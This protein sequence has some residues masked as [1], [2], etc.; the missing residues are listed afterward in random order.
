MTELRR[1]LAAST[2]AALL[3]ALTGLLCQTVALSWALHGQVVAPYDFFTTQAYD[4]LSKAR[5]F[6]DNILFWAPALPD[7]FSGPSLGSHLKL[8]LLFAPATFTV[9]VTL[10]LL[11]AV[12]GALVARTRVASVRGYLLLLAAVGLCIHVAAAIPPLNLADMSRWGQLP[13][14]LRSLIIDG[15]LLSWV[16]FAASLASAWVL[17][18]RLKGAPQ[19]AGIAGLAVVLTAAGHLSAEQH[20]PSVPPEFANAGTTVPKYN[21]VLISLDSLRADHVGCYGYERDTSPT[22]DRLASEGIRF[23]NAISTSSWTLPTHLTM[24]TARYQISHGVTD[25][26]RTLASSIPT[27][28]EIMKANGYRTGGFISGPYVAGHYGYARGMDTYVDLSQGYDHRREAR[29]TIASPA[30]NDNALEWLADNHS[31][32]F[33]LFLHYFDIHYDFIPP[34]PYDTMFDPDYTGTMDGTA[35]IERKDVNPEMD[36]RDLEHILALYDGEIRFTDAH[37]GKILDQLAA[38]G[39]LENTL[40][41]LVSDHGDEFFEHGNKGHHRTVYDEVLRVPFVARLPKQARAG[42]VIDEQVSLVDVMPSILD[43]TGIE[44]P[45]DMEGQSVFQIS[46]DDENEREA[47]YAEFFDKRGFNV[48]LARRTE[49]AKTIQH[50]NRITHPDGGG[51]E[52]FL[53]PGDFHESN[54]LAEDAAQQS[55]LRQ[56]LEASTQWLNQRW[57]IYR[58]FQARNQTNG[59]AVEIDAD[60]AE[61]LKSLG[62]MGDD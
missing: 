16:S 6:A 42:T 3:L 21:V 30:I 22:I 56:E 11:C 35:F 37:V 2:C 20:D 9:A 18:P 32:P 36:P 25:D 40:V 62:Y 12:P 48:Q 33:F 57:K 1:H 4:F 53:H 26:T 5:W 55:L 39:V 17:A 50:F 29:A 45:S 49:T 54:N 7:Q 47:I 24:F 10:G 28:G 8:G 19:L 27:L 31:A 34:A 43:F 52:L 13:Y 51:N 46:D 23:A 60:M 58:G 61:R 59:A 44:G 41:L 14:R 38:Y 15:A